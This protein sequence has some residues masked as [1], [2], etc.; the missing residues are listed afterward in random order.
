MEH[1]RQVSLI[2]KKEAFFTITFCF[3]S[4]FKVLIH[5][6]MCLNLRSLFL[7]FAF[8]CQSLSAY[9]QTN[10]TIVSYFVDN[11]VFEVLYSGGYYTLG[12]ILILS[13]ISYFFKNFRHMLLSFILA[14]FGIFLMIF[15]YEALEDFE[16][17]PPIYQ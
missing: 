5:W 15:V 7:L 11:R 13:I 14:I 12:V 8:L 10:R 4:I 6:I 9:A 3:S 16:F 17:I 1:L 2:L